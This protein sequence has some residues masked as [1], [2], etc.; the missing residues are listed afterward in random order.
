MPR[1]RSVVS[2]RTFL[3]AAS[4]AAVG[5][6]GAQG[7][8]QR[9]PG[10]LPPP[11]VAENQPFSS[12]SAAREVN[13]VDLLVV[14]S[15]KSAMK[16]SKIARQCAALVAVALLSTIQASAQGF[17]WWQSENFRRE[18]GLTQDQSARIEEIFQH[19]LPALRQQKDSLDKAEVDFDRMV[20]KSDDSQV[21]AQVNVVEAARSELH[22][23]RTMMLLRMRR[24]LTPDQRIKFV[25]L[26]EQARNR[27]RSG[28]DHRR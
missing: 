6:T 5:F 18:L 22:K 27:G 25:T 14:F 17:K 20:E 28:G 19:T 11:L 9:H 23:S 15:G 7:L 13:A 8:C 1:L 4:D 16:S 3:P 2:Y 24:V 26:Q 12:E 21:M 10:W